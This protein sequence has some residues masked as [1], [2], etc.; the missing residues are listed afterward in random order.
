MSVSFDD[1]LSD[2]AQKSN[3]SHDSL[4]VGSF[5]KQMGNQSMFCFSLSNLRLNIKMENQVIKCLLSNSQ[6]REV[7]LYQLTCS[8]S[9]VSSVIEV[10]SRT[11]HLEKLKLGGITLRV[12]EPEE[13]TFRDTRPESLD[14]DLS[15]MQ[16]VLELDL[17]DNDCLKLRRLPK[18]LENL[19]LDRC[20][21]TSRGLEELLKS[22]KLLQTLSVRG[23]VLSN[24][25]KNADDELAKILSKVLLA[26]PRIQ[27][28]HTSL[29]LGSLNKE[30]KEMFVKEV[31]KNKSLEFIGI[32]EQVT[33][34]VGNSRLKLHSINKNCPLQ[35]PGQDQPQDEEERPSHPT[36]FTNCII[37]DNLKAN[38]FIKKQGEAQLIELYR[39][40]PKLFHSKLDNFQLD[41]QVKQLVIHK[42][43]FDQ[44]LSWEND[45][46]ESELR[47]KT[48]CKLVGPRTD[49]ANPVTPPFER[50]YSRGFYEEETL[51]QPPQDSISKD[52]DDL[53]VLRRIPSEDGLSPSFIKPIEGFV[54]IKQHIIRSSNL[55]SYVEE[56]AKVAEKANAPRLN[57]E[58]FRT[59]T[60]VQPSAPRLKPVLVRRTSSTSQ[61]KCS[62]RSLTRSKS[63]N[64]NLKAEPKVVFS[65]DRIVKKS[66]SKS[67]IAKKQFPDKTPSKLEVLSVQ[68]K[69]LKK[70][71]SKQSARDNQ[72]NYTDKKSVGDS[73]K[74]LPSKS[75]D[76]LKRAG[77]QFNSN[78]LNIRRNLFK[79]RK[80]EEQYDSPRK[81]KN[82]L[83]LRENLRE[84][85]NKENQ[86]IHMNVDHQR[87]PS[88]K[89]FTFNSPQQCYLKQPGADS[90]PFDIK[91]LK[92][93]IYRS[94]NTPSELKQSIR[95]K[96]QRH[97][98][99]PSTLQ[100]QK[101]KPQVHRSTKPHKITGS[102]ALKKREESIGKKMAIL[103]KEI[104]ILRL[105]TEGSKGKRVRGASSKLKTKV[106]KV[107]KPSKMNKLTNFR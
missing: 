40:Q 97:A 70:E 57:K 79:N 37:V 100:D 85:E 81:P 73:K 2:S 5:T 27:A 103:Q 32:E 13:S 63:K 24:L 61:G 3:Q 89:E 14:L 93:H 59:I 55:M 105:K 15:P 36:T 96:E 11:T 21:I 50:R 8:E 29:N 83:N 99:K 54:N 60:E 65:F 51:I 9:L 25:E 16:G 26:N 31:M 102:A 33:T 41:S 23:L 106:D 74:K 46:N 78:L 92:D 82:E 47:L 64:K 90:K 48:D 68:N 4:M 7:C 87:T 39:T 88:Q 43:D 30:A 94:E 91:I 67:K 45:L 66:H 76:K 104:G 10:L 86:M 18:R 35:S 12:E 77:Q 22:A 58:V 62:N 84:D 52:F 95:S 72:S 101:A 42:L 69:W 53:L 20:S 19:I 28:I 71:N 107:A 49:A 34:E 75:R 6:Y 17:S 1:K 98:K 38:R 56:K 44:L 80:R